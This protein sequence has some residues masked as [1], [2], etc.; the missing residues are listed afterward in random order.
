MAPFIFQKHFGMSASS[1]GLLVLI[2][3][4]SLL[5]ATQLSN[6]FSRFIPVKIVMASGIVLILIAAMILIVSSILHLSNIIDTIAAIA[7]AMFGMGTSMILLMSETMHSV[8]KMAGTAAA[9]V[10]VFQ[11]GGSGL[12][13]IL[14]SRFNI[15]TTIGLGFS[16][17]LVSVLSGTIF[18][19]A[20]VKRNKQ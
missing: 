3:P 11:M 2:P 8:T 6:I 5:L 14:L 15:H 13:S 7:I 20:H 4:I 17:L 18:T 10:G 19:L 1:Y 16:F 9:L 12:F